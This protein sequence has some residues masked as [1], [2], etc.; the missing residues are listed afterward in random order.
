MNRMTKWRSWGNPPSR[1]KPTIGP[2]G[3][4]Y[5]SRKAAIEALGCSLA[6]LYRALREE[7]DLSKVEPIGAGRRRRK[8][9][10]R[11]IEYPSVAAFCSATGVPKSTANQ[12]LRKYKNLEKIV[13][14]AERPSKIVN[15]KD[16]RTTLCRLGPFIWPSISAASREL[17]C[18]R[19]L[20]NRFLDGELGERSQR[21]LA[22]LLV[23]Y[24]V[25]N[26]KESADAATRVES[27]PDT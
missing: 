27:T 14:P 23:E 15:D 21:R 24:D 6:E 8:V 22:R 3:T 10:H 2:D 11:G 17:G 9:W 25:N 19:E 26:P 12:H 18:G 4:I 13:P 20:I 1:S 16:R 7:G 5:P